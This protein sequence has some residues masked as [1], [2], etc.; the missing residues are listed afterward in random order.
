M[1]SMG[2]TNWIFIFLRATSSGCLDHVRFQELVRDRFEVIDNKRVGS[3]FYQVRSVIPSHHIPQVKLIFL[4]FISMA[5]IEYFSAAT[6]TTAADVDSPGLGLRGCYCFPFPSCCSCSSWPPLFY[7][8]SWRVYGTEEFMALFYSP[9]FI[10]CLWPSLYLQGNMT[11]Q[12]L[13]SVVWI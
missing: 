9:G 3:P 13:N 12:N 2:M 1:I 7:Y 4:S 11:W 10:I 8:M 5:R 6:V